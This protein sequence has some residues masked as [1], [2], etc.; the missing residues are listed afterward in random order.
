MGH[1]LLGHTRNDHEHF[2]DVF[3]EGSGDP[4]EIEA[5]QFAA[6]LLIPSSLLKIDIANGIKD[7]PTLS[8]RYWVSD[9]AMWKKLLDFNLVKNIN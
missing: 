4:R 7:I 5:N 2:L 1:F 3:D 9:L 6:E 8:K